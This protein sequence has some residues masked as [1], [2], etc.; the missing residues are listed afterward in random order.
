V[1]LV[2]SELQQY[3]GGVQGDLTRADL[4]RHGVHFRALAERGARLQR[5][6]GEP[7][8][9]VEVRLYEQY[10]PV[11]FHW[12]AEQYAAIFGRPRPERRCWRL[13][14]TFSAAPGPIREPGAAP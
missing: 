7:D 5:T 8:P 2:P 10:W 4:E 9:V 6:S 1:R 13:R 12:S 3:R 11:K 14:E